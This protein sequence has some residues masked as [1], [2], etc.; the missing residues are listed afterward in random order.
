ML[1]AP[2]DLT[3]ASSGISVFI[4]SPT[5]LVTGL[6]LGNATLTVTDAISGKSDAAAVH[7]T[8]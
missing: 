5:G 8:I 4:V 6:A 1:T 2:S 3:Y 7:I